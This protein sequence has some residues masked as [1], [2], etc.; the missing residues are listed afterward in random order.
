[1][2]STDR[3]QL[4]G[5]VSLEAVVVLLL[6]V[7]AFPGLLQ[8]NSG[9][10]ALLAQKN[11]LFGVLEALHP[12]AAYFAYD[13]FNGLLT[14][15]GT[16]L[17]LLYLGTDLLGGAA[18]RNPLPGPEP[19]T[20]FFSQHA[21]RIKSS[22][23][24]ALLLLFVAFPTFYSMGLRYAGSLQG[25]HDG[26]VLHTEAA[27][28]VLLQGQNPYAVDYRS[29][30]FEN[31]NL[32]T[33]Y[34]KHYGEIPHIDHFPYL[35]LS[36]LAGLPVK[37][38]SKAILGWYDQRLFHLL[39]AVLSALLLWKMAGSGSRR[40]MLLAAVFLN[41]FFTPFF[42]EGRNDILLF[43]LM[44]A[45]LFSLKTGR[46]GLSLALM[47]M[48]CCTKQFAW[49]Y[50]PF[51]LLLLAGPSARERQL[52]ALL[53]SATAH[54]RRML[55]FAGICALLIL[56]FLAWGP[57]AFIEDTLLFNAGKCE[58]NYPLGGTPGFGAANLVLYFQLVESRNDYFPFLI[59]ILLIGLPVTAGLL[60]VQK[61]LNSAMTMLACGSLALLVLAYLSRL[62]HDNHLGLILMW[63]TVAA[64]ADDFQV[65]NRAEPSSI[66]S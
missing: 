48:A 10:A 29:T 56:P 22:L 7:S 53:V 55:L 59:P 44:A 42:I 47:A 1:M 23:L 16:L 19:A 24:V 50:L 43:L 8:V 5:I 37:L 45:T 12:S 30:E 9:L 32:S 31:R 60:L 26:G 46:P 63:F 28:D 11:R 35:P 21:G 40:R 58:H 41:P 34:W 54:W 65:G 3:P 62:F 4:N 33:N 27:M 15:L 25:T 20:R 6:S 2:T 17:L 39:A 14:A 38:V 49:V 13:H 66:S 52:P 57:G 64:L 36:F 18:R 51:Y 61:R